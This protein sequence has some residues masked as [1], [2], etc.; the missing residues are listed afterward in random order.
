MSVVRLLRMECLPEDL[1]LYN[2]TQLA[3]DLLKGGQV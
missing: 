3:L 2:A 1:W